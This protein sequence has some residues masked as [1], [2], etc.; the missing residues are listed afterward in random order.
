LFK[1]E[2][3]VSQVF[4]R[5]DSFS[6]SSFPMVSDDFGKTSF[7][8]SGRVVRT[9][10]DFEPSVFGSP[11]V[12]DHSID[13]KGS[14]VAPQ[15]SHIDLSHNIQESRVM[16]GSETVV[17]PAVNDSLSNAFVSNTSD[18]GAAEAGSFR[19][20]SDTWCSDVP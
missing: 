20:V 6:E 15:D 2:F 16:N 8:G 17:F 7:V 13:V 5:S 4:R 9:D 18:L 1:S 3:N 10:V 14:F 19:F 12:M 11:S